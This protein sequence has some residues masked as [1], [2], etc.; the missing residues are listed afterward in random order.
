MII[1]EKADLIKARY[2]VDKV[3]ILATYHND[4]RAY[5][6]MEMRTADIK[7]WAFYSNI[8]PYVCLWN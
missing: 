6:Q 5:T 8:I 1:M 7:S 4:M 2:K 3:K